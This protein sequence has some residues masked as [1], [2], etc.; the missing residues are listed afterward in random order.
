MATLCFRSRL[1]GRSD[2]APRSTACRR[3]TYL[4][5]RSVCRVWCAGYA[6]R[7]CIRITDHRNHRRFPLRLWPTPIRDTLQYRYNPMMTNMR[8]LDRFGRYL[9]LDYSGLE[10]RTLLFTPKSA[11]RVDR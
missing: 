9:T 7:F 11:Q 3:L 8:V 5:T 6:Q 4:S 2:P 10:D 1:L